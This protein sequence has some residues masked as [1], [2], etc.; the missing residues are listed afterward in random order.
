MIERSI[1]VSTHGRY[2]VEAA[3]EDAAA[4]V[5][6][7]FHGYGEPAEL[8]LQ[9]MRGVPGSEQ[10][11]VVAVQGL[12]R[13][14]RGRSED[15]VAS[16]MTRQDR[17]QM[18]ADNRAFVGAV[19]AAVVRE[20]SAAAPTV[21][22]GFSQGVATAF[23]AACSAGQEAGGVIACGG[24]IPPEISPEAL[25]RANRVLVG[26]GSRDE[27]YTAEKL[28]ADEARLHAAGVDARTV[29]LDAGHEWTQAFS[30]AAGDFIHRA[31]VRYTSSSAAACVAAAAR[32]SLNE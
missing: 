9:R 3:R 4:P 2:L 28:A 24:D 5:F 20:W 21:F 26:R 23:R 27:W 25:R 29:S 31:V 17:E 32:V 7:G 30:A 6:I 14:Y 10:W 8:Q 1:Q 15:V 16:W 19:L 18:I 11:I 22:A 13:F 12:H